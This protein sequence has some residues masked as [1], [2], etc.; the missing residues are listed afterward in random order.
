ML[1]I[2]TIFFFWKLESLTKFNL[3]VEDGHTLHLVVRQPFLPS[4]ESL[5]DNSGWI[6]FKLLTINF[7]FSFPYCLM[8][9]SYNII[10]ILVKSHSTLVMKALILKLSSWKDTQYYFFV[11]LP[12]HPCAS[13]NLCLRMNGFHPLFST[14]FIKSY[15][16]E[17]VAY[18]DNC[19]YL[20]LWFEIFWMKLKQKRLKKR[21]YHGNSWK[22][23]SGY[24]LKKYNK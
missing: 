19:I 18:L 20:F 1:F 6:P 5:P 23:G 9:P 10:S 11:T 16:S 14:N 7:V 8:V 4:S 17:K 24:A 15:L 3:D 22:I 12:Y 2:Y 21:S 13:C